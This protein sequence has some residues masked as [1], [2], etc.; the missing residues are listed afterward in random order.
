M[1]QSLLPQAFGKERN[2]IVIGQ[3]HGVAGGIENGMYTTDW[4]GDSEFWENELVKEEIH[5]C[6]IPTKDELC[7]Q[8]YIA[9]D[10]DPNDVFSMALRGKNQAENPLPSTGLRDI[11]KY[12]E[13][14]LKLDQS[15]LPIV[16]ESFSADGKIAYCKSPVIGL[17]AEGAFSVPSNDVSL[18]AEEARTEANQNVYW[19]PRK[20]EK[21][22]L[23]IGANGEQ[24]MI[25]VL[26]YK[27]RFSKV[28]IRPN[29]FP[30]RV[31]AVTLYKEPLPSQ[32][33][34]DRY[35]ASAVVKHNFIKSS[36]GN[37]PEKAYLR[38]LKKVEDGEREFF[39][40]YIPKQPLKN[41]S[42]NPEE[43]A[44]GIVTFGL[45]DLEPDTEYTVFVVEPAA[46]ASDS[47]S[48]KDRKSKLLQLLGDST[49]FSL[50]RK[51]N[52]GNLEGSGANYEQIFGN[53][54]ERD[55]NSSTA[56]GPSADEIK[57]TLI[58]FWNAN[59][60][61][62][63]FR[64]TKFRTP[65]SPSNRTKVVT[66]GAGSC[67]AGTQN[68]L[69]HID[70]VQHDF[71]VLLGDK[72]YNDNVRGDFK[73]FMANYEAYLKNLY[74]Q[75]L[76]CSSSIYTLSDDHEN[77]DNWFRNILI[78]RFNTS[79]F[80]LT[81][82]E[83]A[84]YDKMMAIPSIKALIVTRLTN[85][86]PLSLSPLP[87]IQAANKANEMFWPNTPHRV[88]T[89]DRAPNGSFRVRNGCFNLIFLN[90]NPVV[91]ANNS[92][93]YDAVVGTWTPGAT[94]A[95]D[96]FT[97]PPGE[98]RNNYIPE[99]SVA[100]LK[101]ILLESGKD[102]ATCHAV[103]F[104]S[105]IAPMFKKYYEVLKK[106]NMQGA[107]AA[108]RAADPNAEIPVDLIN[109]MYDKK[110]SASEYDSADNY[111]GQLG[112]L[113]KWMEEKDIRNVF[114]HTGDPHS[115]LCKYMN[116][117]QVIVSVCTSAVSTYRASGYN[118]MLATNMDADDTILALSNNAYAQMQF[119]P[120]ARTMSIALLY[121]DKVRGRAVIPLAPAKKPKSEQE[122]EAIHVEQA[123]PS[124]PPT[125]KAPTWL[126]RLVPF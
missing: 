22:E 87:R 57:A 45:D 111:P 47:S 58:A 40:D 21:G 32:A 39:L 5:H 28:A 85:Q 2:L 96:T 53:S 29:P 54:I 44:M 50:I 107:I 125:A 100:F 6:Y 101:Q 27:C 35:R 37:Y 67:F 74:F 23:V 19:I 119:D 10:P 26:Y 90:S 104:S 124:A 79:Q 88:D 84:I 77:A 86:F 66:Y 36:L 68:G 31:G 82:L 91:N 7:R 17:Y 30:P 64:L 65:A 46:I 95:E 94:P 126:G 81:P 72:S 13:V 108:L 80:L 11:Y 117:K 14:R 20:N 92:V 42:D 122:D 41:L 78:S 48:I 118:L 103:F 113:Q 4:Y 114:F 61:P 97:K 34:D 89:T 70:R 56:P 110:F 109:S 71:F 60:L 99:V 115:S 62:Q 55:L 116:K 25:S 63:S 59:L 106:Q 51:Y 8:V 49:K 9:T 3:D 24:E 76:L 33:R 12:V 69:S 75:L 52:R 18:E 112:G 1:A 123:A 102:A 98:T 105:D 121:G 38:L 73:D 43:A 16:V 120:V 83:R 93:P 15:E